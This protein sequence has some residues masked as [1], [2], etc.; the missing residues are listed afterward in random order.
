MSAILDDTRTYR[1]R[2]TRRDAFYPTPPTLWV[3]LNPSVADEEKDDPTIRKCAHFQQAWQPGRR[4]AVEVVNLFALRATDP[5]ALVGHPDP[6]GPDNDDH[7][8]A[9]LRE[10]RDAGGRVVVA[11]GAHKLARERAMQVLDVILDFDVPMCLGHTRDGSPRHPLYVPYS[12][13]LVPWQGYR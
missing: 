7:I 8:V 10:V 1:Y 12:Q 13:P 2:L 6:V 11:W 9:A 4:G 3:M 5:K